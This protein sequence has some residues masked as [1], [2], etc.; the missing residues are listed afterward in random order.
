V[1]TSSLVSL[2]TLLAFQL[3]PD[4]LAQRLVDPQLLVR[5]TSANQLVSEVEGTPEILRDAAIQDHLITALEFENEFTLRNLERV[6]QG[7][8]PLFE[9]EYGE[10]YSQVLG[11]ADRLRRESLAAPQRTRL[12]K[13][14]VLG[15]YNGDSPF[16]VRLAKEGETISPFVLQA[17]KS[18]NGPTRWNGFDLI[19]LMFTH[20]RAG[21]LAVPLSAQTREAFRLAAREG[22]HDPAP[23]VRRTAVS[24][25]V[26]AMD[27]GALPLLRYLAEKDSD[28][29]GP[30]SVRALA[31]E[32][33]HRLQQSR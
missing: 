19:G 11:L 10:H 26:A 22:L 9:E 3:A 6:T 2:L 25:V 30:W 31:A 1:V 23:D 8:T 27:V 24:A 5:V 13:A 33:V 15:V 4:I 16:A 28:A 29:R 7:K 18:S 21:A 32:G 20:Q 12:L 17:V 14:L